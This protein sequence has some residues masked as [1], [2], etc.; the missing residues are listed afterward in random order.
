METELLG[1]EHNKATQMTTSITARPRHELTGIECLQDTRQ[2]YQNEM[3]MMEIELL[4]HE[5][6]KAT[7]VG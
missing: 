6:S 1:R 4:Q 3:D 7:Q 5:R 2:M